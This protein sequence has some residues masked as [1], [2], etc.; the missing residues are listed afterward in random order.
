M[1][2][3]DLAPELESLE[4][5]VG[6]RDEKMTKRQEDSS[7]WRVVKTATVIWQCSGGKGGG[8]GR[9]RPLT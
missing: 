1:V 7:E 2:K 4:L 6:D 8:S 9:L 5:G 3:A